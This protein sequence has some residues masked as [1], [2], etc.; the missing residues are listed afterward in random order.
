MVTLA[1]V[2]DRLDAVVALSP[3]GHARMT[4]A[5]GTVLDAVRVAADQ[6]NPGALAEVAADAIAGC[7]TCF[8]AA[9]DGGVKRLR[10]N[11]AVSAT[12]AL[13]IQDVKL[14]VTGG[15]ARRVRWDVL[16][17]P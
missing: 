4:L 11:G 2:G 17:L 9:T 1:Q 3:G 13:T 7:S 14:T 5:D 12:A 15:P 6:G 10:A 8:T 16:R